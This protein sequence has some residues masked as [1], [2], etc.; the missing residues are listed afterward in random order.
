MRDDIVQGGWV[1]PCAHAQR[2]GFG[3]GRN[4]HAGHQL[5][6]DLDFGT[7]TVLFSPSI[8]LSCHGIQTRLPLVVGLRWPRAPHAYLVLS[9]AGRHTLYRDYSPQYLTLCQP[10]DQV[11]HQNSTTTV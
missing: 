1:D 5:L 9:R 6:D 10:L 11:K 7:R 3:G 2:H 8:D 4:M